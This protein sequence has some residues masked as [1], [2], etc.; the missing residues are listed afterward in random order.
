MKK[1]FLLLLTV[2]LTLISTAQV[3]SRFAKNIKWK[4]IE[5]LRKQSDPILVGNTDREL[6]FIKSIKGKKTLEKYSVGSLLLK[7]SRAIR[8]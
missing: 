7:N 2:A 6:F 8:T 4:E 3:S 1:I 5:K